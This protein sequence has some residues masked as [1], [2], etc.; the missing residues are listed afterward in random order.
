MIIR[1]AIGPFQGR[2]IGGTALWAIGPFQGDRTPAEFLRT[3][4]NTLLRM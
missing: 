4:L 2:Q 3:P 1:W